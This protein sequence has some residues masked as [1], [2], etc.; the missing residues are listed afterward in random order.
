MAMSSA[1]ISSRDD[2]DIKYAGLLSERLDFAKYVTYVAN[3]QQPVYGWFRF[4]EAFSARLVRELVTDEWVLPPGSTVFDPF[5]GCGTTLLACQELG[6]AAVGCDAMP[7]AVF[8]TRVKLAH[9]KVDPDTAAAA[10]QWLMSRPYEPP[11][12]QWPD[13]QII[14]RAFDRQTREKSLFYRDR[15]LEVGDGAVRDFLMLGLLS[16]LEAASYTA[17]DG[18]FL[19][20]VKRVP[21]SLEASLADTLSRMLIDLRR[22]RLLGAEPPAVHAQVFHGDA[23]SL[24]EPLNSMKGQV[25]AVITSPPYLNRYDYSRTYALELCLML[26][27]G[28]RPVVE[29]FEDLRAIRHSLLRSHIESHPA[30]TDHVRLPLLEEILG[31]LKAK[32]LNN[33]RIPTMIKGYFEDM[34]R[35]IAEMAA[36]LA[37]GGRVALVV[38]NARF[39]GEHLP[40][41]LMLSEIAATH[42][43]RTTEIRVARYKGNSSQQMGRYGRLPVRESIVF[44][45]K[46]GA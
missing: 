5:A 27:E 29:G 35:C 8:V 1:A 41:D 13:V 18:Q 2:L 40:I 42:G 21:V 38:A 33:H 31:K 17:K 20:L 19:R 34:N 6:Y 37:P 25:A 4:K 16:A 32:R 14:N 12:R 3:K 26:D 28:G 45:E 10:V 22:M 15:I 30:P 9:H 44:W 11:R 39:E 23:R 24:P 36:M 7:I 46:S 43:L